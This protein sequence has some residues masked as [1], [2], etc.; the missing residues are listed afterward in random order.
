MEALKIDGALYEKIKNCSNVNELADAVLRI[1]DELI[2]W[3][4]TINDI[5][6]NLDSDNIREIDFSSIKAR[7]TG[8]ILNDYA[9]KDWVSNNFTANK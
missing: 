3:Q 4:K 1:T 9:T 6:S 8:V 2:V 5:L 7:N